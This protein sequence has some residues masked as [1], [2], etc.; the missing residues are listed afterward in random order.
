MNMVSGVDS[1]QQ[2]E[3]KNGSDSKVVNVKTVT[4]KSLKLENSKLPQKEFQETIIP[5]FTEAEP[6]DGYPAIY[7][8]FNRELKYPM[9]VSND[10]TEGI[11]MVSFAINKR[12]RPEAIRITNSLGK[13]FEKESMRVIENMPLWKP[14]TINGEPTVVRLSV[15]LTFSIT[16]N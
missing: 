4:I 9:E 15:P 3:I 13:A 16:K 11:M 10:S 5:K 2:T 1:L 12:G 6:I 14:A 8:Y 7:Q